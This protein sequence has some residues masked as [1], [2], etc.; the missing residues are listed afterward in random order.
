VKSE[1]LIAHIEKNPFGVDTQV[2]KVLI[3]AL[4]HMAQAIG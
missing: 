1:P 4:T 3:D 2:K